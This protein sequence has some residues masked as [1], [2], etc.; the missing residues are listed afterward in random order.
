MTSRQNEMT[1]FLKYAYSF[2]SV[3]PDIINNVAI[4]SLLSAYDID[5]NDVK[6]PY[7]ISF[8]ENL[9]NQYMN[10]AV[11]D[12]YTD[13]T[14]NSFLQVHH[15]NE[16]SKDN[17][18]YIKMYINVT[19]DS[20]Y[21]AVNTVVDFLAQ[22]PE[23]EHISKVSKVCRSD[24]IVLRVKNMDDAVKIINF[25]SSNKD[26]LNNLKR[27]NPFLMSY[28]FLG[29]AFDRTL[30]FNGTIAYLVNE[31]L[32]TK[33]DV[34]SVDANDFIN[35]IKNLYREL[36]S[37]EIT[38]SYIKYI[39]NDLVKHHLDHIRGANPYATVNEVL[40]THLYMFEQLVY[41]YNKEE[42]LNYFNNLYEHSKNKEFEQKRMEFLNFKY[43]TY[44]RQ[45]DVN[46]TGELDTNLLNVKTTLDDFITYAFFKYKDV[47]IVEDCISNF[48]KDRIK[49]PQSASRN[50]TR[51]KDFRS[52]F[53]NMSSEDIYEVTNSDISRYVSERLNGLYIN[54]YESSSRTS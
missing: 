51:D 3:S 31:Y 17:H 53:M 32:S 33:T 5:Y 9:T 8:F 44:L 34:N 16:Y 10:N 15:M 50:I 26:I 35:Y 25:I 20:Y 6:S 29:L 28:G 1:S 27:T 21:N 43:D 24:Q 12:V 54:D 4:Y 52:K 39:N 22:H 38:D 7:N 40:S 48:L 47:Q 23:I 18:N 13:I 11:L 36:S 37:N 2:K 19:K 41:L 30:T 42:D 46:K 14:Q 45:N 49:D